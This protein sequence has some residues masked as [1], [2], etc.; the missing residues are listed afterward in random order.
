MTGIA[1]A[2]VSVVTAALLVPG[3]VGRLTAK[4]PEDAE[5][6]VRQAFEWRARVFDET[7]RFARLPAGTAFGAVLVFSCATSRAARRDY[8]WRGAREV[9][10]DC[11]V[12]FE[13]SEGR[14]YTWVFRL[15]PED[16]ILN[17]PSPEGYRTMHIPAEAARLLLTEQGL[18]P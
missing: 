4:T 16:D 15:I 9:L 12:Q 1:V 2:A 8:G 3:Y 14:T 10:F 11:P 18:L 6:Y 17:K 5:F 7:G 13:D